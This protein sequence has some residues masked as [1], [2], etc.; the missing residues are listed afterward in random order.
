[1]DI[2]DYWRAKNPDGF[3]DRKDIEP[4]EIQD[5]LGRVC[6]LEIQKDPLD[7]I[8]RLDGS[9][10]ASALS[11]DMTGQ[12]VTNV[13]PSEYADLIHADLKIAMEEA[14]PTF[15][16]LEIDLPPAVYAYQRVVLPLR[17]GSDEIS[18][19]M[20]FGYCLDSPDGMFPW[21]R[22]YGKPE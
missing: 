14:A 11:T 16:H 21:N 6:L 15:W 4:W 18:Y 2:H 12:P 8:Y 1:M 19:L 13:E 3:P 22:S 9:N 5:Q 20:T 10:I 17:S 7:F